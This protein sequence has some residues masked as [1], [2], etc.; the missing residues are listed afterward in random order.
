MNDRVVAKHPLGSEAKVL[1]TGVFGPYAQDDEFGS[2]LINPMELY[3]NQVTRVQGPFS[4]RLFHRS[5]GLL[6]L[7]VNIANPCTVLD[8]PS[9]DRFIEEVKTRQYDVIGISAI[10]PNVLK[11]K[12]MCELIRCYQP[13]AVIV[14]GG[15]VT[16]IP[17]LP[18][19]ID[20][21]YI[22]RGD[23]VGWLRRYFGQDEHAPIK[24][25]LE[26]AGFSTR[27]LGISVKERSRDRAGLV[28]PSVGCP[29]GCNFCST[30]A[31]FGGKGHFHN[32][33]ESGDDLFA[34]MEAEERQ[35]G[36]RAF[37][38]MDENFLLQRK[39]ALR[40]LELMETNNKNWALMVFTSARVLH[41]YSMEQLVRLGISWVWI[42]LEGSNSKYS[43]LNG[44]DTREL[45]AEFQ[46]HGIRVL[47]STIIGLED[48]TPEN[49]DEVIDWAVSHN[50]VFH[51]FMLYT[52]LPGTPFHTQQTQ[53]G[54]ILDQA[55]VPYADTHGQFRFNYLHPHIPKGME[56]E[57]LLRAFRRD[58]EVNGPSLA[59]MFSVSLA[60]W[61]RYKNHPEKR[62]RERYSWEIDNLRGTYAGA[63]WAM[64]QYYR[65]DS[66]VGPK[67]SA[68]VK[69]LFSE[70]GWGTALKAK[71]IGVGAYLTIK[72]EERR[73]AK[74]WTYEP[75]TFYQEQDQ[76]QRIEIKLATPTTEA[77][78]NELVVNPELVPT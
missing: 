1:L 31:L 26:N 54:V 57:L 37:F 64:K 39:R 27:I 70:F 48:H 61:R 44:V 33:L 38:I 62:I 14:V 63:A 18:K 34:V 36:V 56:T 30:S 66:I 4:L 10:I 15:H 3:H 73:L 32:F 25:P 74:G 77:E 68:L 51:Q 6:M 42:G 41:S 75:P 20:A 17:E 7:Q 59:R 35:L 5:F 21:D 16:N 43:K 67:I 11:V 58:F 52:P 8:F 9:L 76:T 49:I 60:G 2:R 19:L 50:T 22:V 47:G 69:D 12:K 28:V 71:A 72:L 23:G 13:N 65:R 78:L 40:L 45:V 53:A 24:H 46:A 55:E 29:V